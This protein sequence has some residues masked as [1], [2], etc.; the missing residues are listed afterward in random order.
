MFGILQAFFERHPQIS[1]IIPVYNVEEYLLSCLQSVEVSLR[2]INAEVLV[3]DDGS[4]DGSTDI[5]KTF[6]AEN[7]KFKYFRKENGGLSD[8]RNY[9]VSLARGKYIA[10]V[11]SDDLVNEIMYTLMLDAAEQDKSDMVIIDVERFNS[12]KTWD[13]DIH[14]AAFDDLKE[15]RTVTHITE[16]TNLVYDTTAWNKLIDHDFWAKNGFSFPVGM[17]YEDIPVTMAMH[18]NANQVTIIKEIGYRWRSRDGVSRSITQTMDSLDTLVQR[19]TILRMLV[20]YLETSVKDNDKILQ[21][22]KQ[23]ILVLDLPMF[24]KQ[25]R[26]I[27]DDLACRYISEF[28]SFLNR[29]YSEEDFSG[30]DERYRKVYAAIARGDL[31][32]V[33]QY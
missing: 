32:A 13:S 17:I 6:C 19:L 3:I 9:G 28:N 5:A 4:E 11:D 10:F 16:Y 1:V 31:C 18:L 22:V 8:A 14:R 21:A 27:N 15:Y 26:K 2:K 24:I 33:R 30:L 25:C 7:R 20:D 12:K 29:Y 23:K